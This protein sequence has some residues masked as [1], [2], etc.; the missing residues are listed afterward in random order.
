MNHK[1]YGMI[2]PVT[3]ACELLEPRW[4]IAILVGLWAG[5]T[6]FNE[7]R[8]EV[9]SISPTLL[10]KRLK[11]L[12]DLGLVERITDPATGSVDYLRT[13]MAIAL[14]PALTAL[15]EWA[16]CCV[17]AET[18]MRSASSSNLMWNMRKYVV[19]EELPRRRV[20]IQFRFSDEATEYD[21][22]WVV[23][24]PD[25]PVEICTSIPG[26]DIDLFVETSILSMTGIFMGRTTFAREEELGEIYYSGDPVLSRTIG[27]WLRPHNY[28]AFEGVLQLPDERSRGATGK[29]RM[30]QR[31][32]LSESAPAK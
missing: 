17:D 32:S 23:I 22:H 25:A 8:R 10:S 5:A 6:K 29:C 9:G 13:E 2:C 11:D 21:R 24:Q 15:A 4:T 18:A 14:E 16:Q 12:E 1:P 31:S 7:L 3:R 28:A 27:R 20:V 30:S 19:S 26:F